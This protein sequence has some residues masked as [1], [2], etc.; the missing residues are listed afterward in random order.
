MGKFISAT[1]AALQLGVDTST[2]RRACDDKRLK[3]L[4]SGGVW[5]VDES[6]LKGFVKAKP[7]RKKKQ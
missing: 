7:G 6:S 1:E 3:C 2:I 5:I 4:K